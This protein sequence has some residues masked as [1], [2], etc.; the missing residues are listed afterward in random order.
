MTDRPETTCWQPIETAPKDGTQI[1]GFCPSAYQGKGGQFMLI[2]APS[3]ARPE[4]RWCFPGNTYGG[5][6]PTHWM[7]LAEKPRD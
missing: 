5:M 2:F 3:E 4:G 1:I 7:P 6:R